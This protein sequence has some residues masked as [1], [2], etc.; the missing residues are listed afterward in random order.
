MV[1]KGLEDPTADRPEL[2]QIMKGLKRLRGSRNQKKPVTIALLRHVIRELMKLA[3]D[4]DLFALGLAAAI[5]V[6]YFFLARVGEVV[7]ENEKKATRYI[8]KREDITFFKHGTECSWKEDPDEVQ[9][10]FRG[11]KTDQNC[12]SHDANRSQCSD[13][14]EGWCKQTKRPDHSTSAAERH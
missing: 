2:E 12:P 11:S 3:E 10:Y 4:G 1:G 5:L 8:L 6:M 14:T 7:A 9:I 13:W